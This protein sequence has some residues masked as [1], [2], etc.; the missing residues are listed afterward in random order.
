MGSPLGALHFRTWLRI[1]IL[2]GE[3]VYVKININQFGGRQERREEREPKLLKC[4]RQH[5]V[6]MLEAWEDVVILG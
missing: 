5:Q 4:L 6:R 2:G 1:V 3:K